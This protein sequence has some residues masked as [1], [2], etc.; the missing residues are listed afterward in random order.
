M[1]TTVRT[2]SQ[3]RRKQKLKKET[4]EDLDKSTKK[5]KSDPFFTTDL[6]IAKEKVLD[7][8]PVPLR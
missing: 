3:K 8:H 5:A 6:Y 1:T 7:V 2:H 4:E